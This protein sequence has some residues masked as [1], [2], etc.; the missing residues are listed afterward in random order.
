ME[1]KIVWKKNEEVYG[2]KSCFGNKKLEI[3]MVK[4]TKL[5]LNT[6]DDKRFF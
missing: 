6:F 5:D 4:Q 3:S 2:F 1:M